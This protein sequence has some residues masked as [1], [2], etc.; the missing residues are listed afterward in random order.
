MTRG[1]S[2]DAKQICLRLHQNGMGYRAIERITGVSHNTVINWVRETTSLVC[3]SEESLDE[4]EVSKTPHPDIHHDSIV[5]VTVKN[6][7]IV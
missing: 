4:P 7:Q 5:R 6:F 3:E 2:K 1:Y